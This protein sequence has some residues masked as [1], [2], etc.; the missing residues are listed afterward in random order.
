MVPGVALETP[1]PPVI[2]MRRNSG[3]E[4]GLSKYQA[5]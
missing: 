1:K 5:F 2:R 3:E 4:F